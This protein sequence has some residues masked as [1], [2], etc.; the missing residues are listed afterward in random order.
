MLPGFGQPEDARVRARASE[1]RLIQAL[2]T[3]RLGVFE[4]DV[5]S[6]QV[7]FGVTEGFE[8]VVHRHPDTW[9]PVLPTYLTAPVTGGPGRR[10]PTMCRSGARR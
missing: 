2:A 10:T 3:R 9:A 5:A 7:I 6:R 8:R 1:E 4:W